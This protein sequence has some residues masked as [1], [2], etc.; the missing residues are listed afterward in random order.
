MTDRNDSGFGLVRLSDTEF[1]LEDQTQD[2]RGLNVYDTGGEAIGTVE[3]L[4]VDEEERE[5]RFLA[6]GAGGFWG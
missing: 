2:I 6:V 1:I 5:V 4:Y 3:H